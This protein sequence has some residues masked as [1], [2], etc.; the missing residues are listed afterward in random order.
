M[1]QGKA[2]LFGLRLDLRRRDQLCTDICERLVHRHRTGHVS[3][4]RQHSLNALKLPQS[5]ADRQ[6]FDA[7][8]NADSLNADGMGIVWTARLLGITVPERVAGIDV[9]TDLLP[10]FAKQGLRVFLLGARQDVLVALKDKLIAGHPDLL[11]AGMHHGYEQD[12]AKLAQI[13]R[14][15]GA[16]VLFV[17]LPSPRKELFIERYAD[18][19]GCGFAMGV[20]GAFDVLAGR[21]RRAPAIWQRTGMEFLWRILCQPGYMLPRYA[22][23]LT[24][25]ARLVVPAVIKFQATRFRNW[26]V[27]MAFAV[28][29][30]LILMGGTDGRSEIVVPDNLTTSD[31]KATQ[32]WIESR[33]AAISDPED[34]QVII[35]QLVDLVLFGKV[36][37]V[38]VDPEKTEIDWQTADAAILT[39]LKVIEVVLTAAGGNSFL[40]ET[41]LGGTLKQLLGLHPE[42]SRL[43]RMIADSTPEFAAR[44]FHDRAFRNDDFDTRPTLPVSYAVPSQSV[45]QPETYVQNVDRRVIRVFDLVYGQGPTSTP[46]QG[47]WGA[48]IDERDADVAIVGDA[49]P[50]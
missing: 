15:S 32:A 42:P 28:L 49:S 45:D 4:F 22:C 31:T 3:C 21:I 39:L 47:G 17:A 25:F 26:A 19:T 1:R 14:Q 2:A 50:R 24:A 18:L 27:K 40:V 38:P 7:L 11:I 37:D 13:V 36:E 35:N 12:D 43:S 44:V 33:I 8:A 23:G 5:I 9:M 34:I 48:L 10:R 16:D 30:I 29:A 46:E 41:V 20:G 6:L